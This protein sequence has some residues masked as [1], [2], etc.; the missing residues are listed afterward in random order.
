MAEPKI[1]QR[2]EPTRASASQEGASQPAASQPAAAPPFAA[3]GAAEATPGVR[4]FFFEPPIDIR[5]LAL[6]GLLVIAVF[7]TLRV[8]ATLLLPI[9]LALLANLALSPLVRGLRQLGVPSAIAAALVLVAAAGT[10]AL[11]F[12]QLAAPASEWVERAPSAFRELEERLD[13]VKEPLRQMTEATESVEAA[14]D[15]DGEAPSPEV[16][17]RQPSLAWVVFDEAADVV[18]AGVIVLVLLYF[19]LAGSDTFLRKVVEILPTFKDKKRAVEI[20]REVES[21]ISRYLFTITAIN[22]GLG[23]AI[24]GVTW[25][26]GLPN[27][28]LW[29][30][31]AAALNYVP[32]LGALVSASVI[33]MVSL[34]TLEGGRAWAVPLV[35]WGLSALE[36]TIV[37]PTLL[38]HRLALS[39]VV[40]FLGLFVWGWLWGIPGALIAV[41][42]LV[43]VKI[44]CDNT[45]RLQRFAVLLG[46]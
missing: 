46:P 13:F 40:V 26:A 23:A 15:V 33:A 25:M 35:C 17:V 38:G 34:L 14:T 19:L 4:G 44:V 21:D 37:T 30:A 12:Q 3:Q 43:I 45:M 36:G 41:P 24:A 1:L 7:H 2:E 8:A 6:T 27:P 42:V 39:P 11:A 20:T 32:Y 16:T 5:S 31:L 9:A 18:S 28:L 10:A 29:G 22:L